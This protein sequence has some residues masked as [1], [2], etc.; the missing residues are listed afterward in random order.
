MK[1]NFYAFIFVSG[2]LL[3]ASGC[4]DHSQSTR[5]GSAQEQQ[6]EDSQIINIMMTVDK[7]EIAAAQEAAKRKA[8]PVVDL[9]AKYLIQQHQNSLEGLTQFA[10]QLGL[11]PKESTIANSIANGGKNDLKAL[12]ELQDEAFDKAFIDAMIKEHQE[13]LKLIDSKLL[14]QTKNPQ[15]KAVV[16]QFRQMVSNHLEAGFEIQRTL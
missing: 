8:S 16:E 5:S 12:A 11:K 14:P 7:G 10:K 15:L 9:Y 1:S 13:G 2:M 6:L 3:L 4:S